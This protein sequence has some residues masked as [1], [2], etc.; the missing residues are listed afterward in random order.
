MLGSLPFSTCDPRHSSRDMLTNEATRLKRTAD[1]TGPFTL[2][3]DF[4]L[5]IDTRISTLNS[6]NLPEILF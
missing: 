3:L 2:R 1:Y 6:D 4:F 5:I